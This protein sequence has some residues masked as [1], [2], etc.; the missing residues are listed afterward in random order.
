MQDQLAVILG[1]QTFRHFGRFRAPDPA[2]A[3][4][5]H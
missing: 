5:A 4:V 3:V 2:P 1:L